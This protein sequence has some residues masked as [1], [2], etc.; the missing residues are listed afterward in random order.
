MPV[1]A[2][3]P[4][5]PAAPGTLL[6]V[7]GLRVVTAGGPRGTQVILDGV[8]LRVAPGECV[9]VVGESGSGKSLAVRAVVGLL[10]DG[11]R[12]DGGSVRLHGQE[13]LDLPPAARQALRGRGVT[14]LMQDP[15]T[16]LHPQ[17]TC[18]SQIADGLRPGARAGSGRRIRRATERAEVARRLAEVGL[19]PETADRYP[20]ELSGGMRQRVAVAAALAGDP[21]LLIADEPTTA[22]D[23]ANQRAVLDML[24][25]LQTGRGM[26]LLLITHDLRVAFSACDRVY[27]LYAGAVLEQGRSAELESD[28]RH[29]YTAGLLAAEPS[30]HERFPRLP[31][32]A[33]S[34][35]PPGHRPDGCPFAD[36]CPHAAPV[37][38]TAGVRLRP[39]LDVPAPAEDGHLRLSACV[40]LAEIADRPGALAGGAGLPAAGPAKDAP[41]DGAPAPALATADEDPADRTA[42]GPVPALLLEGVHRT[43][44]SGAGRHPA[45][46][47]VSLTVPQGRITALVGESGSGKTTL[48]RIAVGLETFDEGRAEVGGVPLAPGRRPGHAERARLAGKAQIVFQDPYSSLHPLRT[49]GATLREALA[50]TGQIPRAGRRERAA[51]TRR[52][53]AELLTQTGL[54]ADCAAR[55]PAA[56][57]G[58]ERQRVAVARALAV[59]PRLLVCDEVVSAL[60]VSVQAQVL[61]LLTDLQRAEGFAVLFITH[62]LGVARQIADEVAVMYRGELVEQGAAAD[63]LDR[64]RHAWTRRMLAALP[65]AARPGSAAGPLG[66]GGQPLG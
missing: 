19:D 29:P 21:D 65:P 24:R 59:R 55:R 42:A 10:P 34:V 49:V 5:G 60:D 23:A 26:G 39:L 8:D 2:L 53:I 18:G 4:G 36:R 22:L 47:G 1:P 30:V 35:P 28:P 54:P 50:A 15:F 25:R 16:M 32:I 33:G 44:R 58:G 14:L 31:A 51:W 20:H 57:S 64:P 41:A 7:T 37:C 27:V 11:T 43:F 61:N 56:L 46:R 9:G 66:P 48:A 3:G 52:R 17:L 38:G 62:D 45:A 6:E 40:R 13:I 63:V 12:T